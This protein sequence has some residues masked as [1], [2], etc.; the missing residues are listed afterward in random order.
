M[1][2]S[3][4]LGILEF[5]Q[6]ETGGVNRKLLTMTATSGTANALILAVINAAVASMGKQDEGPGWK[7]FVLF[8]LALGLFVYSLRYILYE[9]T[10][11]TEDAIRSVRVRLAGKIRRIDLAALESIG[12][13]DIHARIS[14]ETSAVAQAARPLFNA[15]QSAVMVVFT[16]LYVAAV[17]PLAL[18]LCLGVIAGGV[19]VYLKDRKA[20]GEG[21]HEASRCEDDLFTSLTGLLKGFKELR[22]NRL[23]SDDVFE[24]FG[25]T[26]TRVRDVRTRVMMRL[27]DGIVF[28]EA[29]FQVLVGTIVFVLPMF[30]PSFSGSMVKIVAAVLFL[31]GPLSNVVM[32]I[33]LLSQVNVTVDNIRRLEAKLDEVLSRSASGEEEQLDGLD[34]FSEIRLNSVGFTYRAPDGSATFQL[35]PADA[36]VRRGELLFLVGGNGS[37]KTTFMKLFTA[38]Y[39]PDQGSISVD[40][41]TVSPR[42]VQS[43]RN[44]FSAIFSDFHLFDRLYGLRDADPTG[45]D[46]LLQLMEISCKTAYRDG[47]FTNINLSTGQRKRLAL[48]VAYLEDKPVYVFDEVAADQ[49]PHFRTYFYEVMLADL[50]KAG[51]TVIAISHDDRFFHVADRVLRMEYGRLEEFVAAGKPSRRRSGGRTKESSTKVTVPDETNS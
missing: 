1:T 33:P 34:G 44:L 39:L 42:N 2:F 27:S 50:K 46:K 5:L 37:G 26:A 12:E 23:K 38:L 29:F 49:D 43:Y 18:L 7:H 3:S 24:E 9:S 28:V 35:G 48:V 4:R 40:G 20:I 19:M 8:G 6:K 41:V 11:L 15:G 21:M 17:S 51:K 10:T 31:T 14:R 30:S 25:G 32:I 47:R 22:I 45:V 16:L 36:V 13:A